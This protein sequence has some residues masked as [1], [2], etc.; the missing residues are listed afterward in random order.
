[1]MIWEEEGGWVHKR[2]KKGE[3]IGCGAAVA[4]R[5]QADKLMKE[6]TI[7]DEMQMSSGAEKRG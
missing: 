2:L 5:R 3:I 6:K 4:G 7:S 1:M